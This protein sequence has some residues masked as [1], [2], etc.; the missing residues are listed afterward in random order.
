MVRV[1]KEKLSDKERAI[2]QI[3]PSGFGEFSPS[4]NLS[5]LKSLLFKENE[6]VQQLISRNALF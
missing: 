2:K 4:L 1:H 3:E 6:I 5:V